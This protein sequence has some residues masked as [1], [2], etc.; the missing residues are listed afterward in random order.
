MFLPDV[1]VVYVCF[2]IDVFLQGAQLWT[3][4]LLASDDSHIDVLEVL[5]Q[6]GAQLDVRNVLL[7]HFLSISSDCLIVI[8]SVC[9]QS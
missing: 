5:I 6:H 3:P 2:C 9:R 8:L 7:L 1:G 4:V